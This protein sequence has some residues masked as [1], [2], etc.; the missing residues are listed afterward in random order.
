MQERNGLTGMVLLV[1]ARRF[2]APSPRLPPMGKP[3]SL[4]RRMVFCVLYAETDP[5]SE[6]SKESLADAAA[7]V[8]AATPMP[9]L[10]RINSQLRAAVNRGDVGGGGE[11]VHRALSAQSD[12][13]GGA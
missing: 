5:R 11:R 8:Y 7:D 9:S 1:C 12:V 10:I 3:G 4:G 2:A 13:P 6:L